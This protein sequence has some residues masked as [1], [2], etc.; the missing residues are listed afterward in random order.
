M[1]MSV[2]VF[3]SLQILKCVCTEQH[4][5]S[6]I[7]PEHSSTFPVS[8]HVFCDSKLISTAKRQTEQNQQGHTCSF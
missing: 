3:S 4:E 8:P 1:E 2:C 5:A 6:Q 7:K